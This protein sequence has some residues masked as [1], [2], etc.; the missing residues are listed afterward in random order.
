MEKT[1][2]WFVIQQEIVPEK[3]GHGSGFVADRLWIE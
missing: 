1:A 3:W 2:G